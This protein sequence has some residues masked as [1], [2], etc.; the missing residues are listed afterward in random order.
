MGWRTARGNEQLAG[1]IHVLPAV[2]VKVVMCRACGGA[3]PWR[4]IRR[5]K[6][7]AGILAVIGCG[8]HHAGTKSKRPL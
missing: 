8:H 2:V 4:R 7:N 6:G 3:V 5:R 1:R